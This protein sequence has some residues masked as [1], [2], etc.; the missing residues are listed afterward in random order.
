MHPYIWG[1]SHSLS[2]LRPEA[3]VSVFRKSRMVQERIAFFSVKAHFITSRRHTSS[4][5]CGICHFLTS[6]LLRSKAICRKPRCV[7]PSTLR[8]GIGIHELT[9]LFSSSSRVLSHPGQCLISLPH[10]EGPADSSLLACIILNKFT[11]FQIIY[12]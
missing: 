12:L 11:S 4:Q 8:A 9:S 2:S 6:S 10:S 1:Q 5:A 7:L 3:T